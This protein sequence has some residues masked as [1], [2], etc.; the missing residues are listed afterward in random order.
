MG[1]VSKGEGRTVLFV[2]H[3]MGAVKKLCENGILLSN[4][5]L[6]K[7]GAIEEIIQTYQEV[8]LQKE[9][10]FLH[11][12]TKELYIS[13]IK[14]C[15]DGNEFYCNQ[16]ISFK[17]DISS[18]LTS[19]NN[20][21]LLIRFMDNLEQVLFS[22]ELE[23]EDEKSI[24]KLTIEEETFV[25]GSYSINCIIYQPGVLRY[26]VINSCCAFTVLD[27]KREFSHLETFDIGKIY[28]KSEWK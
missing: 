8:N 21:F 24:Y 28:V 14:I 26:D 16:K 15:S 4:G 2:S 19:V 22:T 6:V 1:D 12:N 18:T 17:F 25:K 27:N 20:K 5:K 3:N 13:Q 10:Y 11:D 23:L 9:D 7:K